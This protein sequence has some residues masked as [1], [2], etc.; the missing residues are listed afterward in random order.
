MDPACWGHQRGPDKLVLSG[1]PHRDPHWHED[2]LHADPHEHEHGTCSCSCCA[3]L[4]WPEN[5]LHAL[6]CRPQAALEREELAVSPRFSADCCVCD[7]RVRFACRRKRQAKLRAVKASA[8]VWPPVAA[9][10]ERN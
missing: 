7:E 6:W 2:E 1:R 5:E 9:W 10:R 4:D 8:R 3:T